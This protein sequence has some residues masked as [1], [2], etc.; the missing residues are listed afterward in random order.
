MRVT[1]LNPVLSAIRTRYPPV[2]LSLI[3]TS[4]PTRKRARRPPLESTCQTCPLSSAI[5]VC[6]V[7]RFASTAAIV[8]AVLLVLGAF[9]CVVGGIGVVRMPDL[10]TR[11]H[12]ASVTDTLG[13]LFV[14]LGLVLL[15]GPTLVSVK[16]LMIL[17]FLWITGP[18]STH[19][20]A[21]AAH[22]A[23]LCA[24]LDEDGAR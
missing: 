4:N 3:V 6:P 13:V 12:G 24:D 10:F 14:L 18:T 11:M 22:A 15:A 19:A 21:Q 16:L 20:L 17:F 7:R 2:A 9:F 1:P 5:V 23:G 8:A